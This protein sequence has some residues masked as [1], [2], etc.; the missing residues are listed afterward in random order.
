MLLGV[1]KKVFK[2]VALEIN[3]ATNGFSDITGR[4]THTL[5]S[6]VLLL[7]D[8]IQFNAN[9]TGLIYTGNNLDFKLNANFKLT[10]RFTLLPTDD[11]T[12]SLIVAVTGAS[13]NGY[14]VLS[15]FVANGFLNFYVNGYGFSAAT[16]KAIN[17]NTPYDIDV[18]VVNGVFTL[19]VDGSVIAQILQPTGARSVFLNNVLVLGTLSGASSLYDTTMT[20][21][22]LKLEVLQF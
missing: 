10:T 8:Y 2:G 11:D 6:G 13:L 20:V 4:H 21:S 7:P 17:F 22:S 19:K 16:T 1:L 5:G 3:P 15:L 18:S 9:N 12:L 14:G